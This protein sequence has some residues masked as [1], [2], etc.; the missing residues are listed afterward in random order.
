[1][2]GRVFLT[3]PP[4]VIAATFGASAAP[5]ADEQPRH[6]IAPGQDVVALTDAGLT[7]MR[8]GMIP[9]GRVNA[10]GRP[11]METIVNARAETVFDKSAFA[12]VGRAVLPVNG[13][14]EWTGE[15]RRKTAWRITPMEGGLLCFAAITDVWEAPNGQRL[16][17][18]ATVTCAPSGDVRDVHHR[19]AVILEPEQVSAWL[20][21]PEADL[22]RLMRPWPDGRLTVEPATDVNWE[23]P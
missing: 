13:W 17:Q 3:D 10:R 18:L 22:S 4:E 16:H 12:G 5:I 23:A 21:A 6:N 1:M 19:M 8:W 14:Y 9:V 11:V 2:P 20:R 15:K 7:R